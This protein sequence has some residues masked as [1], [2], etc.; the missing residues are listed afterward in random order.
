MTK[1]IEFETKLPVPINQKI[2][3]N[4]KRRT[5]F[6]TPK[7]KKNFTAFR[8]ILTKR[9]RGIK[10]ADTAEVHLQVPMRADVDAY[11]KFIL[12]G[13]EKIFYKNDRQ[14]LFSSARKVKG[15]TSILVQVVL[16]Y[17]DGK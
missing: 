7:W 1:I 5:F 8:E 11:Y 3:L 16:N 10:P 15:R 2:G 13:C 14:V 9:Y 4:Y 17:A 6:L 12:D